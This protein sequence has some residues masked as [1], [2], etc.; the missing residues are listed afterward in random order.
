M[1]HTRILRSPYARAEIS[2]I[3]S[4]A[5]ESLPG[6]KL[7]M[8]KDNYPQ[9]FSKD[10]YFAGDHVA[11]VIADTE[12]TAEEALDLIDVT[13]TSMPFVLNMDEAMQTGAP[14]ASAQDSNYNI[15]TQKYYSDKDPVT[16]LWTKQTDSDFA[17]FG[18]VEEG[19]ADADVIVEESG[20]NLNYTKCPM[21]QRRGCVANFVGGKL[22]VWGH[23]QNM[24]GEQERLAGATGLPLDQVNFIAPYSGPSFGSGKSS[25]P[26][27]E[28]AA[29]ASMAIGQPV[30]CAFTMEEE[31]LYCWSRGTQSKAKLGFKQDGTLTT[32]DVDILQEVGGNGRHAL[33]GPIEPTAGALYA[34]NCQH[35]RLKCAYVYTNRAR[36]HG[37]Q[38]YGTPE[39]AF[40]VEVAMDT[41]AEV[42]NID[43]AELRRKNHYLAG[44]PYT[45]GKGPNLYM[46]ASGVTECIDTCA[47]KI[48]WTNQWKS[49]DTKTGAERPGMGMTICL[50]DAMIIGFSSS[51][52][53]KV[54]P[55]STAMFIAAV[56]DVGMGQHTVQAQIVAEVLGI[57]Y[58]NVNI[59]CDN[60]DSTPYGTLFAASEGTVVQGWPTYEAALDA[61][62]Q[63]LQLAANSLE[64][65]PEEL[66]I[67]DA[68][69][70]I[71]ANPDISLAFNQVFGGWGKAKEIVGYGCRV[72]SAKNGYPTE[73]GAQ[74]ATLDIDTETGAIKNVKVVHSQNVGKALNPLIVE[75]QF[76][77]LRNG[78]GDVLWNDCITDS[79]T[80]KLLANNLIDYRVTTILD[81]EVEPVIT[82]VPGD[83]THPYGA[84]ACGEGPTDPVAAT[85]ANTVYNAI[86]IRLKNPPY[87]PDKILKALGKAEEEKHE[88]FSTF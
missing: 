79:S 32:M 69:I 40:P 28:I 19:F 54:Y 39:G 63:I 30:K 61:K 84:A 77:T 62:Q 74:F 60:T 38:G 12:E 59:F 76:L 1:L 20:L 47:T 85:F 25:G 49:P 17:G 87:T 6:V 18:D 26:A 42:L 68:K 51:A 15:F 29:L 4:S 78:V 88:K 10:L 67:K 45:S 21:L 9:I 48:Q 52:I 44:D 56:P 35:M 71:K 7:I 82:E 37:W 2:S 75:G 16:G 41:A 24:T 80:G 22:H 5:A 66:D 27:F 64:V 31:M 43:P 46:S 13:Y 65:E 50:H 57:P 11:A 83:P 3:D 36:A 72:A 53:V 81:C 55:D 34:R 73:K 14:K 86:G 70:F 33:S 58:E 23:T 8:Y